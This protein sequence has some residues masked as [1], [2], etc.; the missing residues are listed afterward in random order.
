[1]RLSDQEE[2][3]PC[4]LKDCISQSVLKSYLY[5]RNNREIQS[6]CLDVLSGFRSDFLK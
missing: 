2:D 6:C 3:F 1:M 5:G 4:F